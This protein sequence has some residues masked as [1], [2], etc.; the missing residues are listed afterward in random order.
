MHSSGSPV[1]DKAVLAAINA[2]QGSKILTYPSGS[3]RTLVIQTAGIRTTNTYVRKY[4]QFG[5]VEH[6]QVGN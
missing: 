4:F 1:Y 6:Q 3:K 2:L 5:D